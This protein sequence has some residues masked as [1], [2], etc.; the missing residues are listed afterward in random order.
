MAE[1]VAVLLLLLDSPLQ[2]LLR[3]ARVGAND[4]ALLR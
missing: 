3:A 2:M 1:A 4:V